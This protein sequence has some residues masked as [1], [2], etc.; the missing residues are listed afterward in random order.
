MINSSVV[1][2]TARAASGK[3]NDIY[4][5]PLTLEGKLDSEDGCAA[6]QKVTLRF[7]SMNVNRL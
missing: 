3:V 5:P 2:V 1:K 4:I 6:R 7:G